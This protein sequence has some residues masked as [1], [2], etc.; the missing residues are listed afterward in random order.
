MTHAAPPPLLGIQDDA[1][2]SAANPLTQTLLGRLS[3]GVVRL[4][5]I[6]PGPGKRFSFKPID[7][8]VE[9]AAAVGAEP[10]ITISAGKPDTT[11]AGVAP[12]TNTNAAAFGDFCSQVALRYDGDYVPDGAP[13][14]PSGPAS[15]LDADYGFTG[16][17]ELHALPEVD[18]FSVLNEPNRGQYVWPQG[19][20]GTNAPALAAR[21]MST[22]MPAIQDANPSAQVA[23]GPLASRGAQ[24]GL[25]P[26]EF[27]SA[28][29]WDGGPEPD[30]L[31]LNPYLEG[32]APVYVPND[33][34][35]NG[36]VTLRNLNQL[37]SLAQVYYGR[38]VDV[39][40]TEFA[41]RVTGSVS[42]QKQAQ[43]TARTLR[44]V[45]RFPFVRVFTWF[46]LKDAKG[47]WSS[48][49][50]GPNGK[51]RPVFDL[52]RRFEARSL[53]SRDTP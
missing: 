28:Y 9:N 14:P 32:L 44:L 36:A 51:P 23:L 18:R 39:W 7:Q 4:Q 19:P 2:L 20:K 11:G 1:A 46:L 37:E 41:W 31:A 17:D 5:V 40:L 12:A 50:V 52:W 29:Y 45:D 49:L 43:L 35:P 6:W 34:Q 42:A 22:C 16:A 33:Q 8:I 26:L 48:G 24:G 3:P 21:L 38:S 53:A 15:D 30:A 10:L 25:P 47:Y 27:L 13:A